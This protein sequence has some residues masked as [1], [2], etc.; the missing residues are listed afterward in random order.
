MANNDVGFDLKLAVKDFNTNLKRVDRNLNNFH[1]DF[2]KRAKASRQMW[3]SFIGNLASNAVTGAVNA[4]GN[5]ANSMK[6]FGKE[7]FFAAVNAQETA[8]KFDAVFSTISEKS[9]KAAKDLQR[10]FG[11]G[12][13][14]SKT[15][16][17]ATGDL[18]TGFG[19]AQEASLEL[20]SKVQELSVDLASF[21]NFSG[22]AKGAS[23]AITKALLGE[24]ESMKALGVSIQQK[25][26]ADQVA[27]NK[28]KGLT[29]ETARQAKAQATLDIIM[30]QSKNSIGDYARTNGGAANQ[31]KLLNTRIEDMKIAIGDKLI[32]V[33]LPLIKHMIE[34][35][36][37]N[38]DLL[39]LKVAEAID[40]LTRAFGYLKNNMDAIIGV[41]ATVLGA[42]VGF[43][44]VNA[45]AS[46]LATFNV[47]M[48]AI[49]ATMVAITG[50]IGLVVTGLIALGGAIA[51]AMSQGK[52]SK[53]IDKINE[54]K[55]ATADLAKL[56]EDLAKAKE[57]G[58]SENITGAIQ[59]D[60]DARTVQ[61]EQLK[62]EMAVRQAKIEAGAA[63]D[64]VE[65]EAIKKK[66]KAKG[67]ARKDEL[68]K[69]KQYLNELFSQ[70]KVWATNKAKLDKVSSKDRVA[71]TKSTLGMIATLSES[72][73]STLGAIGKAA[74]V[75]TATIDGIAAVQKALASVPYPFNFVAAGLVGT[76]TA[77]NVAKIAG[78][79]LEH[80]GIVPGSSFAGDSV[81][82]QLNSGE[83]VLNRGQQAQLFQQ[84]NGNNGASDGGLDIGMLREAMSEV[85]IVV[86]ADDNEIA[87]SVSRGVENGII[88]GEK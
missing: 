17:S 80:G 88:I 27:I 70:D 15:L 10:N 83:M 77:A 45:A 68:N 42:L 56:E 57:M 54:L 85:T 63:Q 47:A 35:I 7:A 23:E 65:E 78:V 72:S 40:T 41:A 79:K 18:L 73:N 69:N 34:W 55:V 29:F 30:K 58:S 66:V 37:I 59:R 1:N 44:A 13:T 51:W 6:E 16:L 22:G 46:A 9:E 49:K 39:A 71:N 62:E 64:I 52:D 82:A 75:S 48:I 28:A 43:T 84:A 11:L 86:V 50:P 61:I 31:L 74:A 2:E 26:V 8:S 25:A 81:S 21:T 38:Q 19:F 24:T 4:L 53:S 60:I 87:R 67:K 12:V 33:V 14:E 76:A 20:S 5:L 36:E 3:N 32:P